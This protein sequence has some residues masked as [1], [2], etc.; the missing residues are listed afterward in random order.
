MWLEGKSGVPLRKGLTV[1]PS[2]I[3][4]CERRN[5]FAHTNGIVSEQYLLKCQSAKYETQ[6]RIGDQ[7]KADP[8]YLSDASKVFL[9]IGVKL[10]QVLW[11]TSKKSD[12]VD[13]EANSS[14]S[15][16]AYELIYHEEYELA[17]SL[18]EFGLS[19]P[20][21]HPDGVTKSMMIVNLANAHRLLERKDEAE[22]ILGRVDWGPYQTNF[23]ICVAAI[24][25]DAD[26]VVSLLKET[27]E[28]EIRP[29]DYF[30]WPIFKRARNEQYFISALEDRFGADTIKML[31][32][33]QGS[34]PSEGSMPKK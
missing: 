31:S 4:I 20:M 29:E 21:R 24:L 9:E 2:F 33:E 13:K 5:L 32:S 27:S 1:W 25:D 30:T 12:D 19:P 8:V 15:D 11:R 6:A 22:E 34:T 17:I 16:I 28:K 18:L 7:L 10:C 26:E 23:K 3:E 14:L